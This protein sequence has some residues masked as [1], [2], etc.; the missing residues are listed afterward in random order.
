M[1]LLIREFGTVSFSSVSQFSVPALFLLIYNSRTLGLS[2][3]AGSEIVRI[4][5]QATEQHVCLWLYSRLG[6]AKP[7]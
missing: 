1:F 4:P 5:G 7:Y 3:I 6:R 2:G